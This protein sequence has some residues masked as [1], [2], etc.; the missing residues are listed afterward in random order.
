M[1]LAY[2]EKTGRRDDAKVRRPARGDIVEP[3][4]IGENKDCLQHGE[5]EPPSTLPG[6]SELCA[7]GCR[8]SHNLLRL[9]SEKKGGKALNSK[10]KKTLGIV[11]AVVLI[12]AVVVT[13]IL[14]QPKT[15]KGS[16]NITIEVVNSAAESTVYSV[17]TNAE[18]L[19]QAMEE[20]DGLTFSGT[21]GEYGMMVETV[22]GETAVYDTD[23]AYW[24]FFVNGEDCN[25]GISEQPVADGDAFRIVYE[26]ASY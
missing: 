18:Y 1:S 11:I 5:A 19:E 14:L 4:V 3:R 13:G 26:T 17:A 8:R 9:H 15:Q 6:R 21:E 20:A 16:K 22:N 7:L 24:R 12:A 2:A 25:Y 23:G 10:T